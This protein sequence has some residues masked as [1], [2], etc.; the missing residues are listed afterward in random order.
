MSS[1]MCMGPVLLKDGQCRGINVVLQPYLSHILISWFLFAIYVGG[2]QVRS[3]SFLAVRQLVSPF[4]CDG[5]FLFVCFFH[6][7]FNLYPGCPQ[8]LPWLL[9][10]FEKCNVLS[11]QGLPISHIVLPL[12]NTPME[13][14]VISSGFV[15]HRGSKQACSLPV[16][17]A[18]PWGQTDRQPVAP[19]ETLPR[20]KG[21]G[22][23]CPSM[24]ALW[25]AADSF[26]AS[27]AASFLRGMWKEKE[28][29]PHTLTAIREGKTFP[30]KIF[31]NWRF[32]LIC[33]KMTC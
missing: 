28:I 19:A 14:T 33:T 11:L 8:H 21:V 23:P 3:S 29:T 27:G 24:A 4:N 6:E 20:D 17:I 18:S 5:F 30:P 32:Q 2:K 26:T 12:E 10:N 9:K 15:N 31:F 7:W 1:L 25:G 22:P 16:P 13:I